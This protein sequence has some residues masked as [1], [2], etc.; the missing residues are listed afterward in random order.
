MKVVSV[1]TADGQTV[2]LYEQS[3][4]LVI[5]VSDYTAGWPRLPSVADEVPLIE[6]ALRANGFAVQKIVDP[7]GDQLE[8]AFEEFVRQYGYDAGNRLL[9]YFSGHGWSRRGGEHWGDG[10]TSPL[11]SIALPPWQAVRSKS[12]YGQTL[13]SGCGGRVVSRDGTGDGA[14]GDLRG[15]AATPLT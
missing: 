1:K 14:A 4:A 2:A 13:A 8:K 6:S 12:A 9:F 11:S 3:H 5:G 15:S 7:T 10:V